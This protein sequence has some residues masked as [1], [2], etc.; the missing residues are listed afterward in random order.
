MNIEQIII[1]AIIFVLVWKIIDYLFYEIRTMIRH[2]HKKH[3]HGYKRHFS[4]NRFLRY[5]WIKLVAILFVI[6]LVHWAYSDGYFN[7]VLRSIPSSKDVEIEMDNTC[8]D[9][10]EGNAWAQFLGFGNMDWDKLIKIDCMKLCEQSQ[11]T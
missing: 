5:N 2:G 6:Y 1:Y 7:S 3:K 8:T 10:E 9:L 11:S 4:L